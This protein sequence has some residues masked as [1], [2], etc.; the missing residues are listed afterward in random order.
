MQEPPAAAA[1]WSSHILAVLHQ[2]CLVPGRVALPALE[3]GGG[4]HHT[5]CGKRRPQL[6]APNTAPAPPTPVPHP[7]YR[8]KCSMK[9]KACNEPGSHLQSSAVLT[10]VPSVPALLSAAGCYLQQS[11]ICSGRPGGADP[12][13]LETPPRVHEAK[14]VQHPPPT[15]A[16]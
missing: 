13:G 14:A 6:G 1:T 7:W 10:M 2:L 15:P 4:S 11:V 9:A 8:N 3:Q 16:P 5:S 12:Q